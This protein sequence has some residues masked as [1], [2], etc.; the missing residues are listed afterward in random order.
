MLGDLS[1]NDKGKS[2]QQAGTGAKEKQREKAAAKHCCWHPS[3]KIEECSESFWAYKQKKKPS[4]WAGQ[5]RYAVLF[6][7]NR[8]RD[9]FFPPADASGF[10]HQKAAPTS[11]GFVFF[12]NWFSWKY[13]FYLFIQLRLKTFPKQSYCHHFEPSNFL[14]CY[15]CPSSTMCRT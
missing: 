14:E 13:R 8:L 9:V 5:H 15:F 1:A 10:C 7:T 3:G 6:Q 4:L 11:W 2:T 12:S